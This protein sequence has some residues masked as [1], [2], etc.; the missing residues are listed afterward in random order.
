MDVIKALILILGFILVLAYI[1]FE[2]KHNQTKGKL[3]LV[4]TATI[5]QNPM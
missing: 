4:G 3:V 1:R 2:A 5:G